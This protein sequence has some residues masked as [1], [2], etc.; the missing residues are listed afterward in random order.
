[1]TSGL[2]T[3]LD[4]HSGDER[5]GAVGSIPQGGAIG[6]LLISDGVL[7]RGWQ[8]DP[9]GGSV[10]CPA[11]A[12]MRVDLGFLLRERPSQ[13]GSL[14]TQCSGSPVDGEDLG[15]LGLAKPTVLRGDANGRGL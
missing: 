4:G 11:Q 12:L 8:C 3:D 7:G 9:A 15:V 2:L 10:E 14:N 6:A 5:V 13:G 1:M